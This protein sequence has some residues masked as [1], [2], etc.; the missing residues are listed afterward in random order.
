MRVLRALRFSFRTS[1]CDR[2]PYRPIY[3]AISSSSESSPMW[4][5]GFWFKRPLSCWTIQHSVALCPSF[6]T[7][8]TQVKPN[9]EH[10]QFITSFHRLVL[11]SVSFPWLSGDSSPPLPQQNPI[12]LH[13][14]SLK[15]LYF[16]PSVM[17]DVSCPGI[18]SNPDLV[19]I[20]VSPVLQFLCL[21]Q[22]W[23]AEF[24]DSH[25]LLCH[26][27]PCSCYPPE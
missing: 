7:W 20:G 23:Q 26:D 24:L 16:Q 2:L 13:S 10:S 25:Q 4:P 17:A 8:S 12:R 19:G 3:A 27:T 11:C 1:R 18:I 9:R 15:F 21:L 22:I 14:N 6:S 5:L